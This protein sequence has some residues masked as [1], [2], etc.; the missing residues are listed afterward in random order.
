MNLLLISDVSNFV[1]AF[2]DRRRVILYCLIFIKII[3]LH[4][5]SEDFTNSC[6]ALSNSFC[7]LKQES[8]INLLHFCCIDGNEFLFFLERHSFEVSKLLTS[9][10]L[11]L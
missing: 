10:H 6:L 8:F 4:I 11:D 5:L 1:K 3:S 7:A 9:I 2:S